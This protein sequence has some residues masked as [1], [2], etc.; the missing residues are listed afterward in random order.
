MVVEE[1]EGYEEIDTPTPAIPMAPS[2][3]GEMEMM[4]STTP[5]PGESLPEA[6]EPETLESLE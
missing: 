3:D 4:E 6:T 2:P 1:G 5:E